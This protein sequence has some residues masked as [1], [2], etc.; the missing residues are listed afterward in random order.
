MIPL[1]QEKE[2]LWASMTIAFFYQT[3]SSFLVYYTHLH[4]YCF[5]V[6]YSLLNLY[7]YMNQIIC[8]CTSFINGN[9]RLFQFPDLSI[10]LDSMSHLA[11]NTCS[12]CAV[13]FTICTIC[14]IFVNKKH[15]ELFYIPITFVIII[16]RF[17]MFSHFQISQP[18]SV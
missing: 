5:C 4:S 16:S 18:I 3:R 10:D 11:N 12:K 15:F 13:A 1:S 14:R 9:P 2:F 8:L 17:H 7:T 6:F